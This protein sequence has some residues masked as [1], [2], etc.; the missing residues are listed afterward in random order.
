M[1]TPVAT[2]G[3]L[4]VHGHHG[5]QEPL[6]CPAVSPPTRRPRS[7][8]AAAISRAAVAAPMPGSALTTVTTRI[9]RAASSSWARAC[10]RVRLPFCS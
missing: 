3:Q 8:P 5:G 4:R 10:A 6:R 2:S 7:T 9:P 1:M